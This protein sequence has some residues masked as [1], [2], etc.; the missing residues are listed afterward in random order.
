MVASVWPPPKCLMLL[1]AA[2]GSSSLGSSSTSM[3]RWWCPV[4]A[5]SMP[6]GAM[7]IP[8]RPNLTVNS[9]GTVCPSLGEMMYE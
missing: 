2:R 4:P 5:L 6:A 3:R 7:P 1:V 8:E 9:S